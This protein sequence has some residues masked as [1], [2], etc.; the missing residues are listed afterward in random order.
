MTSFDYIVLMIIGFSIIVSMMRGGV[1]ELLALAGWVAAFYVAKTYTSQLVPLL[2]PDIP[3]ESL[4]VL[5]AFVILLLAILLIASLLAIALS[6]LIKKIG[7]NWLNRFIGAL[8]GFARGLLIVCL[9]VFLAGLTHFPK[10]PRW[11]NAMFS[12]PL[13][14]LV[15]IALPHLPSSITKHVSFD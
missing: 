9:L 2:P 12:S 10:D 14:A 6:S 13:E 1:R 3:T 5:A 8:F 7:L 15:K 11:T 4:K